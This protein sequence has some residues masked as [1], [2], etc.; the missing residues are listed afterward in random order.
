MQELDEFDVANV[1]DEGVREQG[2]RGGR[3][4][5][6]GRS[7]G[8]NICLFQERRHRNGRLL[9]SGSSLLA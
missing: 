6:T 9:D 1:E 5:A 4:T 7:A 2:Q 8:P 3:F